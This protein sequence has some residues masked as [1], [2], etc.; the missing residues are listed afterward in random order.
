MKDW[1]DDVFPLAMTSSW[2][3]SESGSPATVFVL[4][5]SNP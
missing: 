2:A 5:S 4:G 1:L 3:P